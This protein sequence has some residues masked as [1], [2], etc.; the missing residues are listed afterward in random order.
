MW[1]QVKV[2]MKLGEGEGGMRAAPTNLAT[3]VQVP[4]PEGGTFLRTRQSDP[5]L[6]NI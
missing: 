5:P 1:L 4:S 6:A 3:Q 2:E